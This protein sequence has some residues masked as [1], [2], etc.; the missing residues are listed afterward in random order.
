[1]CPGVFYKGMEDDLI[2]CPAERRSNRLFGYFSD[3]LCELVKYD[4]DVTELRG[5]VRGFS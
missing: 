5:I 3:D 4:L 2:E 1:M